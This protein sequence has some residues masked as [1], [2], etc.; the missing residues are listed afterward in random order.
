MNLKEIKATIECSHCKAEIHFDKDEIDVSERPVSL[1]INKNDID[2]FITF[3][4]CPNCKYE[5]PFSVT[6][7]YIDRKVKKLREKENYL[8]TNT[9][10]I[11][12]PVLVRK[13]K[14]IEYLR[15]EII[16]EQKRVIKIYL[17]TE[18]VKQR[19]ANLSTADTKKGKEENNE[20]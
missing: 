1:P 9:T 8:N 12:S 20:T 19:I 15:K 6:N 13:R 5:Y 4:V 18:D 14:E 10:M 3:Y 17:S 16:T 7:N 11:A 2:C